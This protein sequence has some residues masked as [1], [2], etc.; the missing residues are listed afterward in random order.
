[1]FQ[2]TNVQ[3]VWLTRH[4]AI[5]DRKHNDRNSNL[6]RLRVVT[7]AR[8]STWVRES[9]FLGQSGHAGRL[10]R[11]PL[12]GVKRTSVGRYPQ[13]CS[14]V[15]LPALKIPLIFL[16]S[17]QATS[18]AT[19]LHQLKAFPGVSNLP[20]SNRCNLCKSS[21]QG[22]EEAWYQMSPAGD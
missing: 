4:I 17:A 3:I 8:Q 16:S 18:R 11:C 9:P 1:M 15:P 21:P 19:R 14:G 20:H 6:S 22:R 12:L 2:I 5:T 13:T 10:Q 7:L